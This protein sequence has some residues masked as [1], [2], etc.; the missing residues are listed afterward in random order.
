M[1]LSFAALA[2]LEDG[3]ACIDPTSDYN[4]FIARAPAPSLDA[5]VGDGG[6]PAL[7][8]SQVLAGGASGVFY[9][10]CLTTASAGDAT[11]AIYVLVK[12]T[13]TPGAGGSADEITVTM[14]SL[15]LHPTNISQTV[16]ATSSPPSATVSA[17]CTFVIDAGT[18][19]IPG[20]A[21]AVGSDL[22]LTNTTYSWKL[23]TPDASC[24]ALSATV[25]VPTMVDLTQGGNY[26]VF[27]RAPADGSVTEFTLGDFVCAGAPG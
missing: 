2:V 11:Q 5:S 8:C 13:L 15:Q 12:S 25:T 17:Q 1:A 27:K 3:A 24:A 22:T 14:T 7:P 9:G 10:A 20:A 16:G 18:I 6:V 21:N 19:V 4:D 23:L 26:C